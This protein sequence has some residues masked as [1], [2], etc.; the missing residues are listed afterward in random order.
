MHW[1]HSTPM[2]GLHI[3]LDETATVPAAIGVVV[4]D[5][6]GTP[7]G[8]PGFPLLP[9]LE[10]LQRLSEPRGARL[11]APG[12]Q[13]PI[14]NA[15]EVANAAL[16]HGCERGRLLVCSDASRALEALSEASRR[17]GVRTLADR[18]E[19]RGVSALIADPILIDSWWDRHRPGGRSLSSLCGRYGVLGT[20]APGW[21]Q[22]SAA[23]SVELLRRLMDL[24]ADEEGTLI[25]LGAGRWEGLRWLELRG[26]RGPQDLSRLMTRWEHARASA[27]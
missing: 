15:L 2:T 10:T 1:I 20:P 27:A 24:A 23:A 18:V 19:P 21:P 26:C 6:T 25:R 11:H 14:V 9:S 16:A 22:E 12:F 3:D 17:H 7:A 5:G 4:S 13:T 8:V